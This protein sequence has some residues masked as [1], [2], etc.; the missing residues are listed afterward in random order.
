MIIYTPQD[1]YPN[2]SIF[3]AGPSR[4][5]LTEGMTPW[6]KEA[7]KLLT[8][9]NNNLELYIPEP[10]CGDYEAQVKWEMYHLSKAAVIMF[11]VPRNIGELPGFTTNIEFGYWAASGKVVLGFPNYAVKTRYLAELANKHNIPLHHTL[12]DTCNTALEI[13]K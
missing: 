6:R 11:W 9:K 12:E 13:L 5:G 4:R 1:V 3:L 10:Y 8:E 7:V 2:R